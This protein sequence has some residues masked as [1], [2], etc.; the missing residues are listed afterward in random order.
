MIRPFHKVRLIGSFRD[1]GFWRTPAETHKMRLAYPVFSGFIANARAVQDHFVQTDGLRPEKFEVI[2]NGIDVESI[3]PALSSNVAEREPVVGIVANCN[4]PIKRVEDFI[5]AAALVYRRHLDARFM[6]V[7][8]GYLRPQLEVL[9]HSLGLAEALTFTGQVADSIA[10]VRTFDVGVITSETE[11][12]C[13]AIL[14][15]MACGVPVVATATGGNPE[16]V[17]EG[18][19]GY[20]VPVGDVELMA[21]RIDLLLREDDLRRQIGVAN[22]TRVA[23][24]FSLEDMVANHVDYY[25]RTLKG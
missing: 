3:S 18:E 24:E 25:E 5:R 23:A 12:L 22:L 2:Y 14:E 1:L 9:A 11:G 13:N 7:G 10:T 15:Y 6:V 17:R 8:D 16:L 20:L 4:R 19:N 21:K